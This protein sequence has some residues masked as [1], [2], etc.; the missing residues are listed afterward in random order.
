MG[1]ILNKSQIE[2]AVRRASIEDH[3]NLL[4]HIDDLLTQHNATITSQAA[5]IAQLQEQLKGVQK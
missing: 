1:N 5:T 3:R 4:N 2:A